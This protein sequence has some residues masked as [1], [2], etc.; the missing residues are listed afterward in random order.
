[1]ALNRDQI[2][3]A[4]D[5]PT[6]DVDCP[7]WGGT[8]LVRGLNGFER[9]AYEASLLERRGD[10][11]EPI[12]ENTTT[13]LVLWACVDEA[14]ARLFDRTDLY[15]LSQKSAL[16]LERIADAVRDLSGMAEKSVEEAMGNS[17]A[18]P[19]GDSSSDSAETS[20]APPAS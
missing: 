17:D 20:D 5:L 6:R 16:P 2:L 8:V 19:S 3:K 1:M 14:G 9:N 4:D 15:A 11:Y 7:E 13:K 10:K 12:M 18:A